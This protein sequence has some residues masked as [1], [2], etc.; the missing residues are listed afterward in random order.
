[1]LTGGVCPD[2]CHRSAITGCCPFTLSVLSCAQLY[3]PL[4][5]EPTLDKRQAFFLHTD[6]Q[7]QL[8]RPIVLHALHIYHNLTNKT[9]VRSVLPVNALG[10]LNNRPIVLQIIF[11]RWKFIALC[12]QKQPNTGMYLCNLKVNKPSESS[13]IPLTIE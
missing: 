7:H 1:M 12:S 10:Y 4:C 9:C 2:V 6:R 3:H 11:K 5:Y 13:T 8:F